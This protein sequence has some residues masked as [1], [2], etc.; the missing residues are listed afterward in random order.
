MKKTSLVM[1]AAFILIA[2]GLLAWPAV[3]RYISESRHERAFE[4]MSVTFTSIARDDA[5]KADL[6]ARGLLLL[7]EADALGQGTLDVGGIEQLIRR[8]V[9][10]M[11]GPQLIFGPQYSPP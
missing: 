3:T 2:G 1:L 7:D 10:E 8:G 6:T 11:D 5:L 9:Y 4:V